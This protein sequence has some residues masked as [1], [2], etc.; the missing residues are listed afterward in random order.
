MGISAEDCGEI[1]ERECVPVGANTGIG[2]STADC[3]LRAGD[4]AHSF[5]PT[6]GLGLNCGIADAHNLAY[7][8]ALVQQGVALP[9]ILSTYTTER[10]GVADMYSTQ[11]V[12]NG[13][14]IFNLLQSLKTAGVEDVDQ[15]RRNMMAALADPVQ[16]AKVDKG[17]QGQRE[18]F[19]NVSSSSPSF[20]LVVARSLTALAGASYRLCI[21]GSRA[22][23]P[24]VA[25][26]AQV[27]PWRPPPALVDFVSDRA[28]CGST[29]T[30]TR[31]G[32]F[33]PR[34]RVPCE[35]TGRRT[36]SYS[37]MEHAGYVRAKLVDVDCRA[38]CQ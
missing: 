22:A 1:S 3:R 4:A 17:I 18:H 23:A 12:K 11:S 10:R 16:R 36:C 34:R 30:Q 26:L 27:C 7:K 29:S 32:S 38:L 20:I 9:S 15:A 14:Q 37:P 28:F 6:G 13:Q 5:P 31:V 19:D 21:R 2:C 8:I 24:C 33:Q 25:L 35:R